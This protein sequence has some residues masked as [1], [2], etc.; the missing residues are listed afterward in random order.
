MNGNLSIQKIFSTD[1]SPPISPNET[2]KLNNLQS[3]LQNLSVNLSVRSCNPNL[4]NDLSHHLDLNQGFMRRG[5]SKWV[6]N[7]NWQI[8]IL[9]IK[10]F[11]TKFHYHSTP[12][13][14]NKYHAGQLCKCQCMF[15]CEYAYQ[16]ICPIEIKLKILPYH[17]PQRTALQAK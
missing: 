8:S 3:L 15:V 14:L 11:S 16:P 7:C 4:L 12:P 10:G 6:T 2:F 17:L 13:P 9:L 1:N 5:F